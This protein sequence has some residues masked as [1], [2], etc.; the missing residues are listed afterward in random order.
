[1]AVIPL[2]STELGRWRIA[3]DAM[4]RS[5]TFSVFRSADAP[6]LLI[7]IPDKLCRDDIEELAARALVQMDSMLRLEKLSTLHLPSGA[8]IAAAM[9]R[10]RLLDR[11]T[12]NVVSIGAKPRRGSTGEAGSTYATALAGA[13]KELMDREG[14]E[15]VKTLV[16]AICE[17]PARD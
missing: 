3:I 14:L 15:A 16:A 13:V 8:L 11:L 17:E 2:K 10:E 12:D 9:L 1:M 5:L 4:A 7:E 6:L